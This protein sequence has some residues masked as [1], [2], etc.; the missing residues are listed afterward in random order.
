[1]KISA[2]AI[3][4]ESHH[5]KAIIAWASHQPLSAFGLNM[6]GKVSDYLIHIPNGGSRHLLEAKN[7]KAMG[8]M[9]GV[10]DLFLAIPIHP[11]H[12]LWVELKKITKKKPTPHQ[13]EFMM[14]MREMS[15][16]SVISY[17]FDAGK[18]II[19]TYLTGNYLCS[20]QSSEPNETQGS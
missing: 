20:R 3:A 4:S 1:M 12:G 18:D 8:V 7:L 16:A 13:L 15:Y 17:G 9:A 5:Q 11:F 19:I 10:A 2:S 6:P 14:K